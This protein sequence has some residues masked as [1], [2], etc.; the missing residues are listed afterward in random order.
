MEQK[1]PRRL[2]VIVTIILFSLIGLLV[3]EFPILSN[4]MGGGAL[5]LGSMLTGLLLSS[6]VVWHFRERFK[7][8]D[9]HFPDVALVLVPCI[10]FAPLFGSLLNRALGKKV[11][12]TFEFVSEV[13][14]YASGYGILKGE[15]AKPSGFHLVVRQNGKQ[16]RFK[17][18]SQ[19]Y[20]PLTKPGEKIILPLREGFF[21]A[22]VML[23]K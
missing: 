22:K 7:P 6:V 4:T 15:K 14:F 2:A 21:G 17:Y 11:D 5:V 19:A 20:Y 9:R 3:R 12:Q 23:L 10:V 16:H 1:N 18:K 8:W 13:P